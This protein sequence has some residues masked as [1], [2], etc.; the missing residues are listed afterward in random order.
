MPRF[1]ISPQGAV[2]TSRDLDEGGEDR[3]GQDRT[4]GRMKRGESVG[5]RNEVPV[6]MVESA[7]ET[8]RTTPSNQNGVSSLSSQSDGGGERTEQGRGKREG[9]KGRGGEHQYCPIIEEG[10]RG[11][12]GEGGRERKTKSGVIGP[13]EGE[14]EKTAHCLPRRLFIY[15][16]EMRRRGGPVCF[17]LAVN[18]GPQSVLTDYSNICPPSLPRPVF[19]S[20]FLA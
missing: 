17:V 19:S 12:S 20:R 16:G 13:E 15:G 9:R 7:S 11:G 10:E 18:N 3:T 14:V 1:V 5:K 2:W 8:I 4:G 6:M